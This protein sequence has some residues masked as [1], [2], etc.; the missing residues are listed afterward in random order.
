[1]ASLPTN[2]ET[3][4]IKNADIDGKVREVD[5]TLQFTESI[6]KLVEA[7]GVTRKEKKS[8][9][10]TIKA[11]KA[12][13]TLVSG[14]VPEGEIIPLSKF[15]VEPVSL[16]EM[17]LD[18]WR[19]ATTAEAI[20]EKGYEQAVNM[21]T[22]KMLKEVQKGIRTKLFNSLAGGS[23]SA[24]GTGLQEALAQGWGQL[25][26]LF[27]DNEIETVY[28]VNPLDIADYLGK[29]QITVQTAFGMSYIENF[30]GLGTV[31]IN[32]SVPKGTFYATAKENI[33]LYYVDA[34]D[35]D[36]A[37]RFAFTTDETGYIGIHEDADYINLTASDVV[38]CG[39]VFFAERVDG[40]VVGTIN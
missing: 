13:G 3:N 8:A 31:I 10:T 26:V 29:A 12:K 23:G 37:K 32:K 4:L 5:F 9:G 11:Y 2:P 28:F 20:I 19:K 33:V 25:E 22:D 15:E 18:K 38:I 40:I 30:L 6:R 35:D 14:A 1:M 16:G 34:G 36:L 21:T 24:S 7:L 27:E 39:M 17:T